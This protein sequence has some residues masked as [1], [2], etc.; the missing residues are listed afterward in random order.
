MLYYVECK[1]DFELYLHAFYTGCG[2]YST[3]THA[4]THKKYEKTHSKHKLQ[5]KVVYFSPLRLWPTKQSSM[6]WDSSKQSSIFSAW[7]DFVTNYWWEN[8]L[9]HTNK[10]TIFQTFQT[11]H[12]THT[13]R[14]REACPAPA[15][16][17]L[18]LIAIK[19]WVMWHSLKQSPPCSTAVNHCSL[20]QQHSLQSLWL[21]LGGG[22]KG[23]GRM[24]SG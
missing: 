21:W 22:V 17:P 6:A 11:L 10:N 8:T 24:S 16:S 15:L 3:H 7:C 2:L 23:G 19:V 9:H 12:L 1:L 20:S 14:E 5:G 4:H 18:L 13:Q